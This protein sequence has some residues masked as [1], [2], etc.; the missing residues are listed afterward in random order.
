MSR[1]HPQP[2]SV[3]CPNFLQYLSNNK[4]MFSPFYAEHQHLEIGGIQKLLIKII[5][6]YC[7][8]KL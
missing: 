3:S 1:G 7:G 4:L 5:R 8:K 2:G 6:N